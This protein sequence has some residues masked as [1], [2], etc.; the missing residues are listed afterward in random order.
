MVHSQPPTP[1]HCDN[2]TATGIVNNSIENKCPCAMD[3]RYHWL[4]DQAQQINYDV[5]WHPGQENICDYITKHHPPSHHIKV[6]PYYLHITKYPRYLTRALH[7]SV[8][9]GCVDFLHGNPTGY[10]VRF[11]LPQLSPRT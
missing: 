2:S 10:Q 5:Q 9:L 8:L 11:P 4:V 1:I 6:C 7:P 3:M